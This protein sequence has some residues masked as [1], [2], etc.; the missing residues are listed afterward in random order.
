MPVAVEPR[1]ASTYC[2][3]DRSPISTRARR[4][5]PVHRLGRP[6]EGRVPGAVD[7][8][9]PPAQTGP[10]AAERFRVAGYRVRHRGLQRQAVVVDLPLIL[11]YLFADRGR[12]KPDQRERS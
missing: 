3:Q 12:R 8:S 4:R 10:E 7:T 1:E 9:G 11:P 6:G 2:R 5:S